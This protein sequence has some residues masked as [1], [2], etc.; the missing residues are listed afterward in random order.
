MHISM[1][2]EPCTVG[3]VTALF[4]DSCAQCEVLSM[5]RNCVSPTAS[6]FGILGCRGDGYLALYTVVN[7]YLSGFSEVNGGAICSSS[8]SFTLDGRK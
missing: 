4:E 7:S 1:H 8:C 6:D 3:C 5:G 2:S